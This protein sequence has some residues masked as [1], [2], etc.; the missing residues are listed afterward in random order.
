MS[1]IDQEYCIRDAFE[2][3]C[4][5]CSSAAMP[6]GSAPPHGGPVLRQGFS[7]HSSSERL[8]RR[9]VTIFTRRPIGAASWAS[10]SL[11]RTWSAS[12]R[13]APGCLPAGRRDDG[14]GCCADG[15]CTDTRRPRL[16]GELPFTVDMG[17]SGHYLLEIERAAKAC[18][19]RGR[20]CSPD[21]ML[22]ASR[23]GRQR[24]C[25]RHTQ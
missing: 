10:S 14:D 18:R 19:S 20:D 2:Q 7:I 13:T 25:N 1:G 8:S 11:L 5:Y 23:G 21:N 22:P 16:R 3:M 9:L 6:R 15:Q 17:K 12:T 24:S 4:R